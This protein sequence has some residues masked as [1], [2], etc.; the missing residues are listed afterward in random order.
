MI[1][2]NFFKEIIQNLRF[3]RM[4]CTSSIKCFI[5]LYRPFNNLINKIVLVLIFEINSSTC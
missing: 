1:T 4:F 5:K 3:F 2:H